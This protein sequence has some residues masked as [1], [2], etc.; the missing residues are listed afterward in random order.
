MIQDGVPLGQTGAGTSVMEIRGS[1]SLGF[2]GNIFFFSLPIM[3]KKYSM[4]NKINSIRM[5][6]KRNYHVLHPRT[7]YYSLYIAKDNF[8]GNYS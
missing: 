5:Q 1:D 7:Y 4:E 6:R 2:A 8:W 3:Y